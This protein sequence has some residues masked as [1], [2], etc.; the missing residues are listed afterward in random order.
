MLRG[1]CDQGHWEFVAEKSFVHSVEQPLMLMAIAG[2]A[3][4]CALEEPLPNKPQADPPNKRLKFGD[5]VGLPANFPASSTG[6]ETPRMTC[7]VEGLET[8]QVGGGFL[9]T[10]AAYLQKQMKLKEEELKYQQE[11]LRLILSAKK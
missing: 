6:D 2:P 1:K 9:P 3:L 7:D 8:S 4:L 5:E 10:F 11:L